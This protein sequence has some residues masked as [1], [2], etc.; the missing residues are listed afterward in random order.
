MNKYLVKIL[1]IGQLLVPQRLEYWHSLADELSNQLQQ[2]PPPTLTIKNVARKWELVSAYQKT[3]RRGDAALAMQLASAMAG[4]DG[5][6]QYMW[7]RIC[8]VAAEDVGAGNP[9]LMAFVLAAS[10]VF[11]PSTTSP[12]E[13]RALWTVLTRLMCMSAKSRLYCQLSLLQESQVEYG[14]RIQTFH[15]TEIGRQVGK[16]VSSDFRNM[17]LAPAERWLATANWRAEGMSVGPMWHEML[18]AA[19]QDAASLTVIPWTPLPAVTLK[20]L[21]SYAYDKH[22]Q[23]GKAALSRACS[24]PLVRKLFNEHPCADK[25]DALGW[26][27]FYEEGGKIEQEL[28][29]TPMA[30][31]EQRLV[32]DRFGLPMVSWLAIRGVLSELVA[33]G[34]MDALR[35][36]VLDKRGYCD[37][38]IQLRNSGGGANADISLQLP[39][40]AVIES[41]ICHG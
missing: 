7:R 22:T 30:D 19:D 9:D 20:G 38:C 32:A 10:S 36:H 33:S 25:R 16:I 12:A 17:D 23:V 28:L 8:T 3:V 35:T 26:A 40:Q 14:A 15:S 2:P 34:Q 29:S 5:E 31:L 37:N 24:L 6:R 41:G 11:T 1:Q 39:L 21:P 4:L 13:T 18:R 27:M